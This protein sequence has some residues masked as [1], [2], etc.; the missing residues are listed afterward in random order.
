M[1]CIKKVATTFF[2]S[3]LLA[4]GA[5]ALV[6][7]GQNDEE[8]IRDGVSAEL[9]KLKNLDEE[10]LN[11]LAS[12]AGAD[13]LSSYGIDAK[14]FVSS[15]LAGFDYRIE[16]V[17]VDGDNATATV[18]LTCKSFSQYTNSLE[19]AVT[20][21]AEDESIQSMSTDE[22]N[23]K[24]GETIMSSLNELSA[25][26]TSPIELAFAREGNSWS[27]TQEAEQAITNALF[28]N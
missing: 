9:D 19:E 12:E 14:E 27:T 2:A 25:V 7:C 6:G 3:I 16:S 26:E 10:T 28:N 5:M 18:V 11:L 24:F 21:L 17:N 4:M 13:D 20:T 1:A 8:I 22:Q 15:Y 23:M